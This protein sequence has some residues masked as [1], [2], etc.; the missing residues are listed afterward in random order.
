MRTEHSCSIFTPG[1]LEVFHI[2]HTQYPRCSETNEVIV[3]YSIHWYQK[4]GIQPYDLAIQ[5]DYAFVSVP[6]IIEHLFVNVKVFFL[7]YSLRIP[8]KNSKAFYLRQNTAHDHYTVLGDVSDS[9]CVVPTITTVIY[10]Q[11][12]LDGGRFQFGH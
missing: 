11:P 12:A 9:K 6:L 10:T 5:V 2:L 7:P 3:S 8:K 1:Y 4:R